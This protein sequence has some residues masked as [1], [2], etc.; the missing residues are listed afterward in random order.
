MI[1][2]CTNVLLL[3]W[4]ACLKFFQNNKIFLNASKSCFSTSHHKNTSTTTI[5]LHKN[6]TTVP[7]THHHRKEKRRTNPTTTPTQARTK[8]KTMNQRW[9]K[10]ICSNT[11]L[12][13]CLITIVKRFLHNIQES[14]CM[15]GLGI[16]VTFRV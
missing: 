7:F 14:L 6:T 2:H 12:M 9:T 15:H 11:F 5:F 8:K 4:H 13:E 1:F 3:R 10:V 16:S